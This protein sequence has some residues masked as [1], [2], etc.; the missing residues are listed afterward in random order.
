MEVIRPHQHATQRASAEW[1]TG[2]VYIDA[3]STAR[4]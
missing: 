1:F 4:T 2:D 3:I